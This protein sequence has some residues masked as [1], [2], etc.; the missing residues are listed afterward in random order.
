M[1][2][3]F[4]QLS[5][6]R[7]EKKKIFHQINPKAALKQVSFIINRS[8]LSLGAPIWCCQS[9]PRNYLFQFRTMDFFKVQLQVVLYV[10]RFSMRYNLTSYI[11]FLE[12]FRSQCSSKFLFSSFLVLTSMSAGRSAL[13]KFEKFYFF[14][15]DKRESIFFL[16]IFNQYIGLPVFWSILF[17]LQPIKSRLVLFRFAQNISGYFFFVVICRLIASL[18]IKHFLI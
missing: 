18:Q 8:E 17:A 13:V 7:K 16:F 5:H 10:N 14:I 15:A 6:I 11:L 1:C 9:N 12:F 4:T 2:V 3:I